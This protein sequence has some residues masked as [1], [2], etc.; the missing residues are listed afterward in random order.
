M[1]EGLRQVK[2]DRNESICERY[3]ARQHPVRPKTQLTA[4]GRNTYEG[5]K[6]EIH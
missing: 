6:Q 3:F 4:V 5:L 2:L 1:R